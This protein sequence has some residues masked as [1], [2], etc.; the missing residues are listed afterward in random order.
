ME[1]GSLPKLRY[2]TCGWLCCQEMLDSIIPSPFCCF[3]GVI[4]F[5]SS[6]IRAAAGIPLGCN[7]SGKCPCKQTNACSR[8]MSEQPVTY[9]SC[10]KRILATIFFWTFLQRMANLIK[11]NHAFPKHEAI[12]RDQEKCGSSSPRKTLQC[13]TAE[14]R[15]APAPWLSVCTHKS[16]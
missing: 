1:H 2:S 3:W 8:I 6:F 16:G 15:D 12:A 4:F 14:H 7:S 13:S 10:C 9:S 11:I 5:R